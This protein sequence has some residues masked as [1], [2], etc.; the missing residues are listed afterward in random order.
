M[1]HNVCFTPPVF[2]MRIVPTLPPEP[3]VFCEFGAAN[4]LVWL[5]PQQK[6]IKPITNIVAS[7]PHD[8]NHPVVWAQVAKQKSE[9]TAVGLLVASR[10]ELGS[11]LKKQRN[12][13]LLAILGS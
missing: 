13:P 6:R 10:V 3:S 1:I 12:A 7:L 9:A 5:L 4:P 8:K 2:R 11:G